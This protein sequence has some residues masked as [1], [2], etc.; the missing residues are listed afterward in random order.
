MTIKPAGIQVFCKPDEAETK[1]QAGIFIPATTAEKPKTATV[2]A[3]GPDVK[4][5]KKNDR[6]IYRSYATTEFKLDGDDYFLVEEQD[7][8]GEIVEAK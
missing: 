1:T 7:V 5:F 3:V 8:L 4:G 6:V 2:L